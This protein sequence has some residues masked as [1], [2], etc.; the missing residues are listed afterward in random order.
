MRSE[1][2]AGLRRLASV[3]W[4]LN[5]LW[6]P[7]SSSAAGVTIITHGWN[8]NVDGWV[9]GMADRIPAY[10]RFPGTNFTT[11]KISVTKS[12][13]SYVFSSARTNGGAPSI[14]DSGEIIVK[15]DWSS[16]AGGLFPDNTYNVGAA[17]STALQRTDL[18]S[19]LGGH[20]LAEF[21]L[22]L[23]GHSRG[24]SLVSEISRDLGTNGV[25]VDH[26]TTLDPHPLNNDNFTDPVFATDAPVHS[27]ANVLFH[28]DYWELIQ[29]YPHGEEVA[30]AYVRQL[31]NLVG[32][33]DSEHSNTHLWY[34][35]TIDWRTPT[36]DT[37]A[38][39]TSTQRTNWW[40]TYEQQGMVGGLYYSLIGGGD[41]LSFDQPAGQGFPSIRDGYNQNWD[42]GAGAAGNRTALPSN[43]G[44]WPNVIKLSRLDTNA[45]LQGQAAAVGFYYQWAKPAASAATV[46]FLIDDDLNPLNSN[47][48]LL[49][50]MV[51]PGTGATSVG[52]ATASLTLDATNAA[53]GYHALYAKI[54]D[55]TRTRYLYASELVQVLSS[56]QPPALDIARLNA[57]QLRIG[58]N[59]LAGQTVILLQSTYFGGWLPL[60]TNTLASGRWTYT[61]TISGQS[62]YRAMLGP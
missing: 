38:S 14:T 16:L 34:H 4:L 53:P 13:S 43:S 62:Y 15:L 51:V 6:A 45:V 47:G 12:G 19:G 23:I 42:L 5:L 32:G 7:S 11:Y 24:G 54:T 29:S 8:G 10:Y 27:Y 52:Y 33:Y 44:N 58:V 31:Y 21:P 22:H 36:S 40:V 2:P 20:A 35:G 56:R 28:D 61:N 18:I 39:I 9:T 50:Q 26:L 60:A 57:S 55:G 48:R 46:S 30:G 17:T 49:K 59:G 41:R 25:W 1:L 37:E 3:F